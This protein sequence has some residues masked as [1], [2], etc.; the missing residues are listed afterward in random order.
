[1]VTDVNLL[2]VR[3]ESPL[4]TV[5]ELLAAARAKGKGGLSVAGTNVG[6]VD[7]IASINLMK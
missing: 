3:K 4:N 6:Q 2:V 1:M 7:H 5:Q